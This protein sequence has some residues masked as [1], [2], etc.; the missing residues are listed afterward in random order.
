M[1]EDGGRRIVG[2]PI[3]ARLS[4]PIEHLQQRPDKPAHCL[5]PRRA[6]KRSHQPEHDRIQEPGHPPELGTGIFGK[7]LHASGPSRTTTP[8]SLG[9]MPIGAVEVISR[10]RSMVARSISSLVNLRT[11]RRAFK[12]ASNWSA[13]ARWKL[14]AQFDAV[15][16]RH[17]TAADADAARG[18]GSHTLSATHAARERAVARPRLAIFQLQHLIAANLH[19]PSAARACRKVDHGNAFFA[20]RSPFYIPPR[21]KVLLTLREARVTVAG[22]TEYIRR[23]PS[24]NSARSAI[25]ALSPGGL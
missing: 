23:R 7:R 22:R 19:A 12:S 15:V 20:D 5:V 9:G 2:E 6:Q 24:G 4:L 17:P 25:F 1:E 8:T 16:G 13:V 11:L 10:I 3:F 14:G 21:S 18:T